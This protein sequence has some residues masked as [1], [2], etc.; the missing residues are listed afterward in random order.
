MGYTVYRGILNGVY[1]IQE[2]FKWG[3]R[4]TGAFSGRFIV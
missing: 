2:H 1:G 4:Y 3:I